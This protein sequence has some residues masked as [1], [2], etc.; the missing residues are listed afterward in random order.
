MKAISIR[1]LKSNPSAALRAAQTDDLVVVMNR[2]Q[3]Q[4]LL[5]DLARLGV[6]D[7][8]GLKFALAIALFR[9]GNV[10]LGYAARVAG[11]SVSAMIERLGRL[12]VPI[13][14][15]GDQALDHEISAIG[16]WQRS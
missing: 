12:G 10:S 7:I 16:T 14:N 11:L 13:V 1:E 2:Q 3:P 4:A 6:A 5:V 9:Q 15:I 8:S